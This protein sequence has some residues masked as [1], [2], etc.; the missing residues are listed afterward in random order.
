ME[1]INIKYHAIFV[2]ETRLVSTEK[3]D[4]CEKLGAQK[5][6]VAGDVISGVSA[7]TGGADGDSGL[8][9]AAQDGA[10]HGSST[11]D[12][13]TMSTLRDSINKVRNGPPCLT[14]ICLYSM[15]NAH[16]G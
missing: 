15:I 8:E 4:E 1:I 5:G 7:S 11:T 3:T 9:G 16:M 6:G 10:T 14:S 2:S 13:M 12:E